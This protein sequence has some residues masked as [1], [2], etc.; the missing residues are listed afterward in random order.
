MNLRPHILGLALALG[1]GVSAAAQTPQT[2]I[3]GV[4]QSQLDAFQ[5]DDFATAFTYA[6]PT[7]QQL[8]GS[9]ER[10]GQMVMNGYPMVWRP[11]NVEFSS[12]TERGGRLY[13]SL[14]VTDRAGRLH[15]LEYEMIQTADGWEINGVQF[16]RPGS[17]GA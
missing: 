16:K 11:A 15:L 9:P 7:I 14:L 6:S 1:L 8:F 17:F 4:I 3:R 2:D 12:L 10:F 5:A 13:Q